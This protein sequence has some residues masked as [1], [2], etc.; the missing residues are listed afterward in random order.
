MKHVIDKACSCNYCTMI[1]V[2]WG[3]PKLNRWERRFVHSVARYG[4]ISDYSNKQKACIEK[5]FNRQR[6]IYCG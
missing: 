6:R 2:M 5:I 4:W 3:D 1:D